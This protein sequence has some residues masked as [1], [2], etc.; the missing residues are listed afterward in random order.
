MSIAEQRVNARQ[1]PF[2][3]TATPASSAAAIITSA[4]ALCDMFSTPAECIQITPGSF[5]AEIDHAIR[6]GVCAASSDRARKAF[7]CAPAAR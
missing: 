1:Q 7:I 5:Q 6:I 4:A 3:R 2:L